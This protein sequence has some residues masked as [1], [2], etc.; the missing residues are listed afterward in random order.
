MTLHEEDRI[1][2][3]E[4]T[5]A[6]LSRDLDDLTQILHKLVSEFATIQVHVE[7]MRPPRNWCSHCGRAINKANGVCGLCGK[8]S[9]PNGSILG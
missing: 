9:K 3:I 4:K 6:A 1:E 8:Q 2:T 7:S 5:I